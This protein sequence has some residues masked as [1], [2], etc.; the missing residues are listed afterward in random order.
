M[1]KPTI[2]LTSQKSINQVPSNESQREVYRLAIGL[3]FRSL[4]TLFAFCCF[5]LSIRV[6]VRVRLGLGL[7]LG[8]SF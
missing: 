4:L 8:C 3:L 2:K 7:E 5:N 1:L 6:R